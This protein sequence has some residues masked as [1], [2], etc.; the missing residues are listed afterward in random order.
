M[1][2]NCEVLSRLPSPGFQL[3][4]VQQ[5]GGMPGASSGFVT[6]S[7]AAAAA[8]AHAEGF[9]VPFMGPPQHQVLPV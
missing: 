9:R 6:S 8:A 1:L 5:A 4:H 2:E 7:A 3:P